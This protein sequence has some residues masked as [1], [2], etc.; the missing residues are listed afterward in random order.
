[1]NTNI[2]IS[3]IRKVLTYLVNTRAAGLYFILFAGAIGAATF[4]ENDFGTSAAQK[5]VYKAWWFELLLLLF[6][7]TILYN[8]YVYRMVQMKKWAL[9]MFHGAI[10]IIILG[11]AITRYFSFEGVM[12]IRENDQTSEFLSFEPYL[13]FNVQKEG[14]DY[15]FDEP[16]LFASL[17]SNTFNESYLVDGALVKVRL[18]DFIP[19]PKQQLVPQPLSGTAVIKV[20][21]GGSNGR[22]EYLIEEGT[23]RRIGSMIFNFK[24]QPIA[25]AVNIVYENDELRLN[26]HRMLTQTVMA[27]QTKDT[28]QFDGEFKALVLRSLY[29][30]GQNNFV[31][32]EFE[33]EAA[34]VITSDDPKVKNESIVALKMD[35]TVGENTKTTYVYGNKGRTGNPAFLRFDEMDLEISYGSKLKEVP[36][37]IRLNDFIMERY[38]G[39]NSASS[40][41]SEVT[42]LDPAENVNLNYRIFMNNILNYRGYRFFQSSFDRDEKGT[43]LS[44]NHDF[45]G[46]LVSYIGYALLTLGMI[47]TFFS[48][49]TRFYAVL[50]KIKKLR[51]KSGTFIAILFISLATTTYAQEY[52]QRAVSEEHAEAFSKLV[53]Q[54]FKGRMKPMHTL[55]REVMRKIAR[56]ESWEGLTADQ[57]I[58]GMFVNKQDWYDVKMIKLGKHSDVLKLIGASDS[59]AS[60]KDFFT[61]KGEYKLRD[62]VRRV[63]GLD[64]VDRGVY[65]KELIKIDERLNIVSM[66]FS[67]SL[68]KIVPVPNDPNNTWQAFG[69]HNH[70]QDDGHDHSSVAE[71]FFNAYGTALK[72]ATTSRNFQHAGHL[73]DEL[74]TFQQQQGAAVV[75]SEGKIN[76]EI[77]LNNMNVFTRLAGLYMILGVLL[78]FFLFLSVFKPNLRLRKVYWVLFSIILL[79]FVLHTLGL[80]MR[81]YVSGRAPWSNGYESMI[82][83][84]WTSTLAGLLFTRKSFGGL[85]ATMVL[86]GTIL[87]VSTLSFLD[88]EI[89]PLV[90]VLR[91]YWLTIHVSLEAGSYGF[92]MLGAIIGLINLILMIF[93][94]EKNKLR[95]KRIVTEMSYISE[96]TLI[97]G[98]FMMSV[99]TYLGGVWA[100]ES[101]GRYWGWDA[102]ETWALVTILV[103]AFILHMRLIPKLRG[104]YA[105]NLATIF[106]LASVIMTYYGVNYYLS[107]LH[108]Y[109]TGDPVPIPQWVY[110]VVSCVIL[111]SFLAYLRKRT[112]KEIS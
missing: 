40:Y 6:A 46:T 88:P 47:L 32:S 79:G 50:Q 2:I 76:T 86:A 61:E 13:M 109:A 28:I 64:P 7:C 26:Y 5:L 39:T 53:V 107:G 101:W 112:F 14:I 84:A 25:G 80:G 96:L 42:L 97:G 66:L 99:G 1:M 95:V 93:L 16:V 71:R 4:I 103:Y 110:I 90:P 11:A 30:D 60:Y 18:T 54:D 111:I 89:T 45:W 35:V 38:P 17:G 56:K 21:I 105:F 34:I 108:S 23:S 22:E 58:L 72:Q 59:Y 68:L 10:L 65:A 104:T 8:I 85:A 91:S 24:K 74:K 43:Y 3:K 77:R 102:K 33:P 51:A 83:I 92:L 100:N 55:S 29:S 49:K 48:K 63:Y 31:F 73:L 94:T 78:L 41:A 75:P 62:E 9:L 19:N 69:G 20:V 57:V 15:S 37:S 87:F 98:L 52:K 82:Y 106:G 70:P 44:V 27:T 12:H 81:W 67:G 36:F